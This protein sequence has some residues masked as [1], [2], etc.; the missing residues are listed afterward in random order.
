MTASSNMQMS[1][2]YEVLRPKNDKALPIPCNEWDVLKGK[3]EGITVEPWFFHTTGSILVGAA[4]ATL[5]SIWTGAV[6]SIP[7]SNTL[8]IAW[9]ITATTAITGL[10]CLGFAH[11]ERGVQRSKAS[12]VV[13]QMTLIEQRFER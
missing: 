4:L 3:I 5:I 8:V 7:S 13:T 6:S 11:K 9:A 12:D 10:V 1:Q 2:G